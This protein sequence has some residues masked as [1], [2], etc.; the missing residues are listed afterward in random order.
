L[1]CNLDAADS[2]GHGI[3]EVEMKL[4]VGSKPTLWLIAGSLIGA[5]IITLPLL[6]S[7]P[8]VG[9]L[10]WVAFTPTLLIA[11]SGGSRFGG[12]PRGLYNEGIMEGQRNAWRD[13]ASLLL[14]KIRVVQA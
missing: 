10:L 9:G 1:T 11:L 3:V 13:I 6:L 7:R 5:A 2:D 14:D 12:D 8:L 4:S